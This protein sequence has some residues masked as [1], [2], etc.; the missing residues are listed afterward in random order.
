MIIYEPKGKAREYSPL[1]ANFY[2]G[3]DHGCAYCYAP[4]VARKDREFYKKVTPRANIISEY[5]KSCIFFERTEKQVLF[6][7]MGDPY[8]KEEMTHEIT[9]ECIKLSLKHKIPLA[10]LSKGGSRMLRDE[11]LFMMFG[12]HI[13]IGATLTFM[14]EEKS[15]KWEPGA[16]LPVDRLK[17][18]IFLHAQGIKT[19]ASFEPVID[20]E[21]SLKIMEESLSCVDEYKVGKINNFMGLDKNIDWTGFLDKVVKM[22]RKAEKPFYI[23]KD[24]R[25]CAPSIKLYENEIN[26][27]IF[28]VKPWGK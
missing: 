13:K 28:C 25:E 3:C 11:D 12:S 7:F 14:D 19:W 10:I 21:E 1:A 15:I 4:N 5:K 27:D 23:K 8:C 17:A 9:R 6:N 22:L 24:L 16:A 26:Q 18:L 2:N 20:P